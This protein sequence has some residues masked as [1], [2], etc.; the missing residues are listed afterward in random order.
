MPGDVNVLFALAEELA[1]AGKIQE[2]IDCVKRAEI[3]AP[4][5]RR[6]KAARAQ[7]GM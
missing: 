4:N 7:L 5:D 2:A 3:L 6:L 1:N